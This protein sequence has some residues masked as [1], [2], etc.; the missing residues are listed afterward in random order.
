MFYCSY[1]V[2]TIYVDALGAGGGWRARDDACV[3]CHAP[4]LDGPTAIPR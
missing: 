3:A 2:K 4:M 1:A